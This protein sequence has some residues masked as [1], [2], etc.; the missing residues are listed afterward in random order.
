V[1]TVI[2]SKALQKRLYKEPM[3]GE[4]RATAKVCNPLV[5]KGAI[6]EI[7]ACIDTGAVMLLLGRDVID[8][9]NLKIAGK[10]VIV[11]ADDSKQEM[12]RAGPIYLEMGD[13]SGHFD[14]L[15]GPFGCEPLIGQLVLEALDLIV[16]CNRQEVRPRPDSPAYPSYKMK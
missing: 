2:D 8:R 3:M 6:L 11:L 16:D 7:D 4:V 12:E 15:V 10:A 14:C 9:L 1:A 13:R 5:S